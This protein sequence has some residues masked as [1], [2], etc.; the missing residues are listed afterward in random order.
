M[1]LR[2]ITYYPHNKKM[3]IALMV[4]YHRGEKIYKIINIYREKK[5][6]NMVLV[7]ELESNEPV[8]NI[9]EEVLGKE[10]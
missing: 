7:Q 2:E 4:Q 9:I 8:R 6:D 5:P 1:D 10:R 3:K